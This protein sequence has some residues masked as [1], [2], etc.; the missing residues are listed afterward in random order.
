MRFIAYVDEA[1]DEGFGKLAEQ[2]PT[3]QSSWFAIGACL[4]SDDDDKLLP[5]WRDEILRQFPKKRTLDLHFRDLKHDQRVQ[6]CLMIAQRPIA[7]CIVASNKVTLLT[8]P[9]REI[10]KKKQHLYNYL[11]RFLLE[12]L[13]HACKRKAEL[14]G[15]G[16]ASLRVI[17]SRRRGTDYHAMRE[18]LEFMRD[19]R[20]VMK[21]VRTID[22]S[23]LSPSDIAVEN[24]SKRAGLQIADVFTSALW[25][26]IEPNGYGFCESRY[27]R[28]LATRL[29]KR[30]GQRLDCGLTLVPA[31]GKTPLNN[32]QTEF[33]EWIRCYK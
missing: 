9:K 28:S 10:F 14:E 3:A 19:G 16:Q 26:A 24:H 13:T 8:H 7:A 6:T 18:Y 11:T 21:P 12:R 32:E 15:D 30:R 23:V 27:A 22:W 17:F 4:V 1:G 2:G 20:E 29:I 33:V 5:V 25:H 31:Y